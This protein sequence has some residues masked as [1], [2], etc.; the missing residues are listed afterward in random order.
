MAFKAPVSSLPLG[1]PH[2]PTAHAL[3]SPARVSLHPGTQPPRYRGS[4]CAILPVPLECRDF[5]F[6]PRSSDAHESSYEE[7]VFSGH[8]FIFF[9]EVLVQA[10][11]PLVLGCSSSSLSHRSSYTLDVSPLSDTCIVDVLSPCVW[12]F[13]CCLFLNRWFQSG[14]SPLLSV[15]YT[16]RF[17]CPKKSLSTPGSQI[18]LMGFLLEALDQLCFSFCLGLWSILN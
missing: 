1:S 3:A 6:S 7:H 11:T 17:L 15:F 4:I 2:S 12:L 14:W 13:K 8:S 18:F 16:E 5:N 10:F 9:Y